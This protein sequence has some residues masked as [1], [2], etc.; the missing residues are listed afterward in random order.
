ML[1]AE[2]STKARVGG[3]FIKSEARNPKFETISKHEIRIPQT[4]GILIIR[5]SYLFS[6]SI[7]GFRIYTQ[8]ACSE[9][10]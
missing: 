9:R 8:L 4:F 6:I 2:A 1:F 7:F 5:I 3:L 10:S